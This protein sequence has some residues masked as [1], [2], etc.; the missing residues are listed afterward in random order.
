MILGAMD[1]KLWVFEVFRRSLGRACAGT[2]QQEATTC[3]KSG[4][5]EIKKVPKKRG[6]F[7]VDPRLASDQWFLRKTPLGPLGVNSFYMYLKLN[8]NLVL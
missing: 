5:Q 8:P 4:G 3:A 2:N 7:G 1:Q 6:Q